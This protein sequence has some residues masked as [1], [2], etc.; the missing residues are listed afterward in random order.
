MDA[1]DAFALANLDAIAQAGLVAAGELSATELLEAAI[2]RLEAARGLNAVI[3][4]LF[5]R[6]REQAAALDASGALRN[7]QRRPAGRSSVPAQGPRR[8]VGRGAGGDGL[9]RAAHPRR[10]RV[11]VDR[12]SLPGR[13][14]RGV[15]QDQHPRVGQPLHHRAVAVRAHRQ[16]VV[17]VHHAR[18]V[19]R[20]IGRGGGGRRRARRVGRRRHRL[21]PG[22]R[23]LLRP[24]RPQAAPRPHVV[25]A[26]CRPRSGGSGQRARPDQH[27]PR[28]RRPARR[29]GRVRARRPLHRT[30]AECALPASDHAAACRRSAF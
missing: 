8:V 11:G 27:R 3:A 1:T 29:R 7:G 9:T 22:A 10:H 20:R 25:R 24:R 23:V 19:Q 28:Q 12:R 6:G 13:R 16:P 18:R 4:D 26:G 14:P 21:D 30:A 17:A 15:R 5:D 2:V